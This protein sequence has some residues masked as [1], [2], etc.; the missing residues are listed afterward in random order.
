[1]LSYA[2]RRAGSAVDQAVLSILERRLHK[3]DPGIPDDVRSRLAAWIDHY[4]AANLFAAPADGVVDCLKKRDGVVDLAFASSYRPSFPG[5]VDEHAS[6]LANLTARARWLRG[7]TPGP[8]VIL[9][10]GWQA[11]SYLGFQ[12]LLP[13]KLLR[14]LGF[15]VVMFQ[16]PFHAERAPLQAPGSGSLFP[17]PHV[18]RTNETFGQVISDLRVLARFLRTRGVPAVGVMGMSLGGYV[19]ALWASLDKDLAFAVPI[20]PAANLAE[21]I[22]NFGHR[23]RARKLSAERGVT[24]ELLED[25]FACHAPLKRKPVL[26]KDRLFL[27]AGEGDL[28][29]PPEQARKLWEHWDK[30]DI[31]WFPGGHLL[32]LGRDRAYASL[33]SFL[34]RVR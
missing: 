23:S 11:G 9:I 32:Q 8:T 22:W 20:V 5:Y 19:T 7:E 1:L 4:N 14:R 10:H 3:N 24:L 18:V 25:A 21:L 12:Q 26:D 27:I 33:A 30:P 29:A 28:V 17:S 15:D 2:A 16:L 13:V 34:E 6:Y 31:H